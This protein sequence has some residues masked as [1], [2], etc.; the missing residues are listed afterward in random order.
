M[1]F[2]FLCRRITSVV[3]VVGLLAGSFQPILVAQDN[4]N[5]S[6]YLPMVQVFPSDD[7][8]LLF[9]TMVTVQ[10][11]AKWRDL[12]RMAPT[13]VQQGDN[14]AL[15]IVDDLQLAD[16]ARL[17]YMPDQTNGLT[18]L[19]AANTTNPSAARLQPLAEQSRVFAAQLSQ[20]TDA[21]AAASLQGDMH[22]IL[23][24]ALQ[25]LDAEQQAFLLEATAAD[26]DN[27]GL[28]DDQET[29]WCTSSTVADTDFDSVKDGD[30]VKALKEWVNNSNPNRL[31]SGPPVSGQPFNGWPP[32]NT[33]CLDNDRDSIPNLAELYELGLNPAA[34]STD[35]DQ[36]DDGQ[37][38][39]GT[40]NCP[41]SGTGC[42]YGSL[43]PASNDPGVV[44]FPEMPGWVKAPGNHPLVAGLPLVEIDIVPS[45]L[46]VETVTTITTD[47]SISQGTEKSYSTAKTEGT[48]TSVEDTVTW[49]EWDEVSQTEELAIVL[50]ADC[51]GLCRG[52]SSGLSGRE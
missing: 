4:V 46:R 19:I 17:G 35:R 37:E 42:G 12:E 11:A 23:A 22:A 20:E 39:F 1:R 15:L 16:L 40:T 13:M 47:K 43:P 45:S 38:V 9:R 34:E 49:N 18:A 5:S 51:E 6:L 27:D 48:S 28:T 44:L 50:G 29:W 10:T 3:I 2:A 26:A 24:G 14:W 31:R 30:E 41:G 32:D 52:F 8:D 7:S 33:G 36:F 21:V 25:A